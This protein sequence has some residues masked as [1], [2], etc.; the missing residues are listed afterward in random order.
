MSNQA[1]T[2]SPEEFRKRLKS[3][4]LTKPIALTGLVKDDDTTDDVLMFSMDGCT[5]WTSI[6]HSLVEQVE[7]IRH[8]KCKDH[9]HPLVTLHLKQS[10]HPEVRA[11]LSLLANLPKKVAPPDVEGAAHWLWFLTDVDYE[12]CVRCLNG[13][14]EL[15]DPR[16]RRAC[17]KRCPC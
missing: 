10:E 14:N 13:C 17:I 8:V 3:G 12:E 1:N 2:F 6:P 7:F 5:S 16:Q 9:M 15:E 11:A 4:E